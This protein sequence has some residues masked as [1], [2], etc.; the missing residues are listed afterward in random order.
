[1]DVA[2]T[3]SVTQGNGTPCGFAR[4]FKDFEKAGVRSVSDCAKKSP[5]KTR[6]GSRVARLEKEAGTFDDGKKFLYKKEL[7]GS[8]SFV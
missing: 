5:P 3:I 4:F 7:E 1:M 6:N 8:N 2:Y